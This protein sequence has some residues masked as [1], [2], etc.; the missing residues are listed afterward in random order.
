MLVSILVSPYGWL[1]DQALVIPALLVGVCRATTREQLGALALASA[2]MEIAQ[3]AGL[4]M[5]SAFYLWTTPFWLGW[6]W[7][8]SRQAQSV[9]ATDAVGHGGSM[10]E[11]RPA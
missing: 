3:M 7:Y 6:Y 1:T 8:V 2:A 11:S 10:A 4:G 5:H 9:T